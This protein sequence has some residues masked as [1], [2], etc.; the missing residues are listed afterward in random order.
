[1]STFPSILTSYTN[2]TP[3]SPLNAPSHSGIETAQNSGLSQLEATVGLS[4]ASSTLGTIIGDLRSPASNGGGHV[5]SANAGGTG[6]TSFSKGDILVASSQSVLSKVAV[7]TDGLVLKADS[8][9]TS[10]VSW[11]GVVANKVAVNSSTVSIVPA[12]GAG[13]I[14]SSIFSVAIPAS[15]LSVSNAIRYRAVMSGLTTTDQHRFIVNYGSNTLM[16]VNFITNIVSPVG[17]SGTIEGTIVANGSDSSQKAYTAVSFAKDG[18]AIFPQ[19]SS[20]MSAVA[21]GTSSVVSSAPQQ[22]VIQQVTQGLANSSIVGQFI[23]VEKIL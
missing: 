13:P 8:T 10:G 15:V 7:G 21:Y 9:Q 17:W 16:S 2:P 3:T 12:T 19:V 23:V 6:Q 18:V 20:V 14:T 22:L 1:M 4:G 11:S 5:Q